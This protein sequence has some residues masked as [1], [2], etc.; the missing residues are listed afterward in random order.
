M[1]IRF[2]DL[3]RQ[4]KIYREELLEKIGKIV[5]KAVFVMGSEVE[6]FEKDFAKFC[7]KKFC[8]GLNSGTDGLL[9]A[10]LAYDIG[11][12]DEV[13][14]A[15]NSYFSTAM[16][17]SLVGA[18]P[19]FVDIDSE[20]YNIDPKKIE[21]KITDKTRA[22]IPV[23]LYGQAADM[24][25][26]IKIAK[27]HNLKIIEDCCQA[28]G[29]TY[30][31]KKL[32]VTETGAFSFYPGK[33]LGAFGDSG[34]LVTDDEDIKH[35]VELLKNDGSIK[36]YVHEILGYKSRLDEIQA[37]V[38]NVKL[39][40][41]GEFIEKRRRAA[42]LYNEVLK[43]IKQ[44]KTPKEMDYGKHAYHI[45]PLLCERRDDLQEFL[46]KNGVSA[47]IHYPTP[48]HLQKAY[49]NSGYKKGDFPI[50]ENLSE[51]ELSIPMFP[52]ITEEEINFVADKIKEFYSL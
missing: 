52:E 32:P 28:H 1:E 17:V 24:D 3:E 22:I 21:E 38:L 14:T 15:P 34:G 11:I 42:M 8:V 18:K 7:E 6:N 50:S 35:T 40:Y 48:I 43:E 10:L 13:I 33:N 47:V 4:N 36:K 16:T 29:A 41:L 44:I 2:V 12:G 30:K 23:H 9:F 39:K 20:S 49:A 19:V 26:I 45:Y 31:G 5:D 51:N 25:P 37:G 27:K 46:N